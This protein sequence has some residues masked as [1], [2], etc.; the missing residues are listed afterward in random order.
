MERNRP[1]SGGGETGFVEQSVSWK[2]SGGVRVVSST[3][4]VLGCEVLREDPPSWFRSARLGLLSNQA[5]VTGSFEHTRSIID[6][7]GGRLVCLFSPQ[8]G[9]FSEKQ[10][11]MVESSDFRME[12]LPVHSLYGTVRQ[13][14]PEMLHSIDVLLVDLQDVGT[15]VYTFGVTLGLCM[16]TAAQTGTKI[17]VLDRPNPI[18]G[19]RAEGNLLREECRSFVGR[20]PIPMRHGLTLGELALFIQTQCKVS[21]D[22]EIV[23]MKGWRRGDYFPDTRLPWVF[24]S[25]NMPTWETALLYPGMVLLEGC[26]ISEGRGTTLPF[27]LFGAPFIQ[28]KRLGEY[29]QDL[30]PEGVVFRPACFEPMFDKWR[31]KVCYGFQVHV[32]DRESFRP[33]R[34][35]LCLLCGFLTVCRGDFQWLPPPYE[36]EWEKLPVDILLGDR[37]IREGLEAGTD[38][39]EIEKDWTAELERYK[40]TVRA[41]HLY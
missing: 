17:V 34:L 3:G 40:E 5:S 35:G 36:Y 38:V 12:S 41:C 11:N 16:E 7:A 2:G 6:R 24:P 29:L 10:A 25:P 20:Y 27:R 28:Q 9:F 19:H 26:N 18:G 8:H 22:L 14:S 21:C 37:S 13:P 23:R 15:R 39:D 32:T 30:K 4:V 1:W 31:G 33:Y